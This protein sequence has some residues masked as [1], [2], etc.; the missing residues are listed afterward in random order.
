MVR[1][2]GD[3]IHQSQAELING[4]RNDEGLHPKLGQ[5]VEGRAFEIVLAC[6][7]IGPIQC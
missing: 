4:T 6:L 1:C 7:G 5:H 2:G 3:I